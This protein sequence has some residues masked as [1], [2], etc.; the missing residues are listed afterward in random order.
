M[1]SRSFIDLLFILLLSAFALLS[2]SLRVGAV[3]TSPADVGGGGA[4]LRDP[5][6]ARVVTI[7]P[8]ALTLDGA[9]LPGGA[10]TA[11]AADVAAARVA[12]ALDQEG[13]G[14]GGYALLIPA[15]D[16]LPHQQ[17]MHVWAALRRLGV[18]V[19][20]AVQPAAA[21]GANRGEG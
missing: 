19:R 9:E 10:A 13:D 11:E 4:D 7:G 16:T 1:P 6:R 2:E 5:G 12:E 17:V 3:E 20:L 14:D 18:D 15:T 8:D 21:V